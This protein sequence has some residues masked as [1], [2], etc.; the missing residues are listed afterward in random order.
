MVVSADSGDGVLTAKRGVDAI[1]SDRHYRDIFPVR[2][3][4]RLRFKWMYI[5]YRCFDL[6]NQYGYAADK[7]YKRQRHGF[8]NA[9]WILHLG[10][11]VDSV[12]AESSELKQAFDSLAKKPR[13]RRTIRNLTKQVWRAWRIGRKKDPELY[14]AN[15][16]FKSKYGNQQLLALAYPRIRKD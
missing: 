4:I 15:N 12:P 7:D 3:K 1:F 6:L 2:R 11:V 9:L 10:M 14:T 5:A 16:F 13:T 8:W